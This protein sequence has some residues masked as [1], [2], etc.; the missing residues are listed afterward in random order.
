MQSFALTPI[1]CAEL[2]GLHPKYVRKLIRD[3]VLA[4]IKRGKRAWFIL[5][6]EAQRWL[7]SRGCKEGKR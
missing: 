5:L 6:E 2:A 3:G 7:C 4:G 1:Q